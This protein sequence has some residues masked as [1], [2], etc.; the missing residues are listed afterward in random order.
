MS[1]TLLKKDFFEF[2]FEGGLEEQQKSVSVSVCLWVAQKKR[3]IKN[4]V[5]GL[6]FVFC[7]LDM[8]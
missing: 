5:T 3:R 1:K 4:W 8:Y 7:E 2:D 6:G